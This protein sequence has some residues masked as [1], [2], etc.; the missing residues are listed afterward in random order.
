VLQFGHTAVSGGLL[1]CFSTML[2]IGDWAVPATG[3]FEFRWYQRT[4]S[5]IL[6]LRVFIDNP[7]ERTQPVAL[8]AINRT[9]SVTV[10]TFRLM[11]FWLRPPGVIQI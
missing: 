5:K 2:A 3:G 1:A 8:Q 4:R 6:F 11:T 10:E 7:S 9:A